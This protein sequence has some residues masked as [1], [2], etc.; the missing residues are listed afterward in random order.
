M[1]DLNPDIPKKLGW[2]FPKTFWYANGAEL[3]E[4]AAFYGMFISLMR[5]LNQ[6]GFTDSESGIISALFS[7]VLYLFPMFMGIMA[8]KIGF[9]QALMIA[10]AILTGG[11]TLLGAFQLKSTAIAALALIILG[12]AIVK[13]V[14]SGTVAKCSD[15]LHRARAMSIFYMIVNIGSFSGKS[16]AAP[17]NEK[18]GLEYI[19]FYAAAMAFLALILV[20]LFY[21]NVDSE[22][23]GK[24][25]SEA[26]NGLY[27]A[28]GNMRFLSLI[29]IIAGFWAI[30]GQLYGA[31]PS[32]IER[33]LG[34]GYKPEW[35]ANINPFVVVLFVVPITHMVRNFKAANAIGISLMIIP[36]TAHV[37]AL[38]PVLEDSMGSTIDL[39]FISVHPLILMVILGIALQGLAECFL[40]PKW[41]EYVSK[42]APKDEVG[43]YL[44]YSHLTTFFAWLFTF[45]LA[46]FLL[47]R[48]CPDPK[49]FTPEARHEWRQA[50]DPNYRF[51]LYDQLISID[52]PEGSE[53]NALKDANISLSIIKFEKKDEPIIWK[54]KSDDAEY[55][56]HDASIAPP[57]RVVFKDKGFALDSKASLSFEESKRDKELGCWKVIS[58][59]K[60]FKINEIRSNVSVDGDQMKLIEYLVTSSVALP[61]EEMKPLPAVYDNAHYIWFVFT[62]I[63]VAAFL[64]LLVFKFTTE[65]IDR[66]RAAG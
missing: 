59:D 15:S 37:I 65:S 62:G 48:Y 36:F 23:T 30:Q 40:S 32:Y 22:G 28:L 52:E 51:C 41:L 9:K 43:L 31:M 58:M 6:I 10:F 45:I 61:R 54:I 46:G 33:L 35:L 49:T 19:N 60:E 13:P 38:A 18:W 21:K 57:I 20:S 44:G 27:K 50:T 1:T 63:G 29:L 66:K 12:G 17:L 4:R 26:L 7:S 56:L 55:L 39:G 14:I 24:T 42:Q 3:F 16:L 64:A 53:K 47:E 8:D 34:K 11:Y 5:Y 2:K 25:V